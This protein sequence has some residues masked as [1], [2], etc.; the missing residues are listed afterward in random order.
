MSNTTIKP[1]DSTTKNLLNPDVANNELELEL[2]EYTRSAVRNIKF[3]VILK[4][5]LIS[6]IALFISF[7]LDLSEVPILGNITID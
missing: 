2:E 7:Y 5:A 6:L 4:P 3:T 1:K